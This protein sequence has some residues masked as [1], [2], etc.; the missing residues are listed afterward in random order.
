V[1]VRIG[2]GRADLWECC[3][4]DHP[5]EDELSVV[6]L[7][8]VDGPM[9]SILLVADFETIWPSFCLRIRAAVAESLEIAPQR[10]GIFSTQNHGAPPIY[11]RNLPSLI[12]SFRAA[13]Q[14][15]LQ[16]AVPAEMAYVH[17]TPS[18]AGLFNR[19]KRWGDMGSFSFFYGFD[20]NP[21]GTANCSQLLRDSIQTL[22]AGSEHA[23]RHRIPGGPNERRMN[24][25]DPRQP[26]VPDDATMDDAADP[27][28]QGLFFRTP[29]GRPIGSLARWA[30]H[31][32]TTNAAGVGHSGDYPLYARRRLVERF[33]GQAMFMTGP[34]G[35]QAPL[36]HRKSLE[37]A[38]ATGTRIADLLLDRLISFP[39]RPLTRAKGI[40]RPIELPTGRF[41][42]TPERGPE[43]CREAGRCF[44]RLVAENAPLPEIK[45]AQERL[46]HLCYVYQGQFRSW[47]GI[48]PQ[49]LT[50]RSIAHELFALSLGPITIVGLPGEPFGRF[51]VEL[52]RR[53]QPQPI[54]V[55]EQC[56]GYLSYIPTAQEYPQGGYEVAAAM[57]APQ[58]E[59]ILLAEGSALIQCAGAG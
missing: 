58:A 32:V 6:A 7:A 29:G 45:R 16:A 33:G 18:P 27:L 40:S 21:D 10:V 51:S 36:V 3:T 46:E 52:R 12:R 50:G 43:D 4:A 57:L 44:Q 42:P 17:T 54:L 1:S 25:L 20:E 14:N 48:D 38:R 5:L 39:W 24:G 8:A 28:L 2:F 59:N 31:P 23:L 49:D 47:C 55:I 30:A 41:P 19:R 56:N 37:L 53:F 11:T 26:P 9:V 34:C 35:D 13:A 15:A 22:C